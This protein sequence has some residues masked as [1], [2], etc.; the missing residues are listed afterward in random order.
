MVRKHRAPNG[1]L[2]RRI[3]GQLRN[4]RQRVLDGVVR[5]YRTPQGALRL[6]ERLRKEMALTRQKAPS[7]NRRIKT[8]SEHPVEQRAWRVR[9]HLA[10][11]GA[12]GHRDVFSLNIAVRKS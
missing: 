9:K 1:A 10:P 6:G 7:A 12:L 11:N 2:R 5:N 4:C 3:G 8:G